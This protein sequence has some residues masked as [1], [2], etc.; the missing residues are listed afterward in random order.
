MNRCRIRSKLVGQ[1]QGVGSGVFFLHTRDD[2][3]GKVLRGLDVET[4]AGGHLDGLA[5]AGPLDVFGISREGTRHCQDFAW[6]DADIFRQGL[7][8]GSRT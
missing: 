2:E 5:T 6:L 3:G 1:F 8:S 4:S 7:N